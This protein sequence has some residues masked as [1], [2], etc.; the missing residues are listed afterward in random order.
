MLLQF[1]I[2]KIDAK[3]LKAGKSYMKV[4]RA[5]NI[6]AEEEIILQATNFT[7]WS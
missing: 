1:F 6:I 3:L 2:G 4:N 7:C 5:F